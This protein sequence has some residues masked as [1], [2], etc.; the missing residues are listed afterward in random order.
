MYNILPKEVK[1]GLKKEYRLRVSAVFLWGLSIVS[2]IAMISLL[3][4]YFSVV[5]K[6]RQA[7]TA[8]EVLSRLKKSKDTEDLILSFG[9]VKEKMTLFE[10]KDADFSISDMM[11]K[12]LKAKPDSISLGSIVYEKRDKKG[13][14]V[15]SGVAPS[16]ADLISFQDKIEKVSPFEKA[17][18]PVGLLAKNTNV[19]FTLTVRGS[20]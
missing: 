5:I 14:F 7:K 16:R 3:P 1:D 12:I 18:L 2:L 4:S 8:G 17:E 11:S 9:S 13:V 10:E 15:I 20:F 6:E 19:S